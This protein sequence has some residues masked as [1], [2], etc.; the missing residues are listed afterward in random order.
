MAKKAKKRP[1]KSNS[2]NQK[3]TPLEK[4]AQQAFTR[5][6]Q[7]LN[8]IKR[9]NP[10]F[11]D[12]ADY[13]DPKM[14]R[15][16]AAAVKYA[17]KVRTLVSEVCPDREG[18]F[19]VEEEWFRI[20][21]M[22]DA[23]FDYINESERFHIAAAIWML[24]RLDENRKIHKAISFLP[25]D[26]G[27]LDGTDITGINDPHFSDGV[28][29]GMV[30]V[31]EFRNADCTGIKPKTLRPLP[32]NADRDEYWRH[33]LVERVFND[34]YITAE[35]QHQMVESRMRFDLIMAQLDKKSIEEAVQHFEE[36]LWD[37][38]V[39]FFRYRSVLLDR[40]ARYQKH[41]DAF[42]REINELEAE[43]ER[44]KHGPIL[45]VMNTGS[46][47]MEL[48]GFDINT[49][50]SKLY[51]EKMSLL[52][53]IYSRNQKLE[54]E[55][56]AIDEDTDE[57]VY[58]GYRW[59]LMSAEQLEYY[60]SQEAADIFSDFVIDDPYEMCFA[61]LYL[62]ESGSDLPWLYYPARC[63]MNIAAG[64]LPW[65]GKELYPDEEEKDEFWYPYDAKGN[66]FETI[67]EQLDYLNAKLPKKYKIPELKD[68]YR[69]DYS[70][71]EKEYGFS[72][73]V[74][75]AQ[76]VYR[77]T[78]C[79]MPRNL[80]RYDTAVRDLERYGITG[81]KMQIPLLYCLNLLGAT[82]HQRGDWR[83]IPEFL[84]DEIRP[85]V[86]ESEEEAETENVDELKAKIQ[87]QKKEIERLKR[88]NYEAERQT[89][90][91]RKK[92]Q[93]QAAEQKAEAQELYDLRELVFNQQEGSFENEATEDNNEAISFPY[94]TEQRI[95]VF[96][97]HDTWSKAI[98]PMLP[99]VRFVNRGSRPNADM[100]R[101]A[102]V[103][104]IQA[105][106]LAH[107]DFYAIINEVRK[108]HIPVRYFTYA[109][110]EHCARQIVAHEQEH[111]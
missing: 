92:A 84:P 48:P 43:R 9:K 99:D 1:Q 17:G 5:V 111:K 94:H 88:A 25:R 21:A 76:V 63:V 71:K 3:K 90:D 75:L 104:W 81:K 34:D 40:E 80:H 83:M 13:D 31:I 10:L 28:L 38:A 35:K 54:E 20:N 29:R 4:E 96:G 44:A 24:D 61:L 69:L 30:N 2:A 57:L 32:D 33:R 97:G 95:V 60:I 14:K 27:S 102:D 98:R 82:A 59:A 7:S 62:F 47:P 15:R 101:G 70:D 67:Q 36:K 79:I 91:L 85:P 51:L 77:L 55:I 68:W 37:W 8:T 53:D 64:M 6:Q 22:D 74:N 56:N 52:K 23:G 58:E 78:G 50:A 103:V 19:R 11:H 42:Q 72:E 110:A 100:I 18:L 49:P 46:P 93:E 12:G 45:N 66:A 105:N 26:D 39:R 106:A 89:A 41:C 107:K 65:H 16:I 86:E 73:R 109:S 108:Y 87:A